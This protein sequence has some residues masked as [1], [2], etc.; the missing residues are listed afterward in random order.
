M[1]TYINT[2]KP[3]QTEPPSDRADRSVFRGV[4]FSQCLVFSAMF[5]SIRAYIFTSNKTTQAKAIRLD[6]MFWWMNWN[7]SVFL[8]IYN[9][10][11]IFLTLVNK[12]P[13]LMYI[14]VY[15]CIFCLSF[16]KTNNNNKRL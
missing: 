12:S 4:R 14:Y 5:L 7:E 13:K 10:V 15:T 11:K 9:F 8:Y 16:N 2:A 3:V 1:H 6:R